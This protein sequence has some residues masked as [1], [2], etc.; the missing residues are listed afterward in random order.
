M[1]AAV[2]YE[3]NQPLVVEDVELDDPKAGEVHVRIAA[4]GVCRSDL[5]FMKGEA[6][7]ALPTVLGHEGSAVVQRVGEGVT[8]VKPGDHVILS[9]VPGC[10][11]CHFCTIGRPNLCDRH[12]ATGP[13][14]YDGTTRLHKGEQRISHMGKVACFAEEAVVPEAGCVPVSSDF[15][16]DCAALIGCSATTGIGAA[17]LTAGVEAGS[18]VA[19]VG[20]G[21]VGLN[22]LQGARLSNAGQ[23][24]AVDLDEGKL[25]FA[26]KFGA[27]HAVNASDE[28]AV[29][30]VKE[31]TGGLG[32]DYTFEVFGS[33]RTIETAYAMARKG[34]TVTVV[35]IAPAGDEASIDAVSLTRNEKVLKG[36]YYGSAR[37]P[38]DFP[39]MV[40]MYRSGKIDLDGL[41]TRRYRLDQINQAYDDLDRG[42]V[43]RG[44]ITFQ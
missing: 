29:A 41:I 36:S 35:G 24:I 32:A 11:R 43:G 26:M 44:V 37:P 31:I 28:D 14:L 6:R 1:K 8:S 20:C 33:A 27:T 13:Y 21:G 22:V 42:E 10:G 4:A 17:I 2:L 12:A 15:P 7:I 23:V 16:M 38:V 39:R 30:R 9:F 19:V 40:E 18:S 25:E 34:G 5:H 3:Y